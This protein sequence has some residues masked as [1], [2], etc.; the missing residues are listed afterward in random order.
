MSSSLVENSCLDCIYGLG[1]IGSRHNSSWCSFLDTASTPRWNEKDHD[2]TPLSIRV[3]VNH[4]Y[5]NCEV[6]Q[7][8]RR[9]KSRREE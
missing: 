1:R 7:E 3:S 4:F 6:H 5:A 2:N 8:E 9:T